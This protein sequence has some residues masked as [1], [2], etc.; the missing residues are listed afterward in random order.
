MKHRIIIF[1]G[2][3]VLLIF[4]LSSFWYSGFIGFHWF[5][6]V[7]EWAGMDKLGHFF[8]SFY[9]GCY[10][11]EILGKSENGLLNTKKYLLCSSGFILMLPIELLDGFSPDY[12]A[13]IAD[14]A[15]NAWGSIFCYAFYANHV[16]H[17][18]SPKF[19]FHYT[20]YS[21]MRPQLLGNGL[22][23]PII[24]DYNGQTYWYSFNINKM[25]GFKIFPPW[26]LLAVGMSAE[27]LLGGHDNVWTATNGEKKDY[28]NVHRTTRL[29][30]SL[31]IDFNY[32][33]KPIPKSNNTIL[34]FLRMLKV[35]APA[36]EFNFERGI[37]FHP[38]YF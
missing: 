20:I 32:L 8:S 35:P 37:I 7:T 16:V 1:S 3:Y 34:F 9:I 26:L 36:L 29:L 5:D 22:F 4:I 2:G 23:S 11:F 30:L 14:I 24:K 13:S 6:D 12:G 19:S 15:A 17:G 28:S 18:I 31:D 25:I 10:C 33:L 21:I 38:L 27:G